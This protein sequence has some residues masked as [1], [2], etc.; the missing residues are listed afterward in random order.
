MLARRKILGKKRRD[1]M[2]NK[3]GRRLVLL[4]AALAVLAALTAL[5]GYLQKLDDEAEAQS[6]R[7]YSP[8][9]DE[10]HPALLWYKEKYPDKEIL[11]ACAEDINA[12]GLEDLVLIYRAFQGAAEAVALVAEEGSYKVTPAIPAPQQHQK[13]RYFNMDREPELEF[14]ITGDKDGQVGYA[15]YRIMDGAIVNLFGEGMEDCC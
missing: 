7:Q 1:C 9:A 4:L 2:M 14:L 13:I 11:L 5:R 8:E 3:N 12:D 10:N 6:S 15:V